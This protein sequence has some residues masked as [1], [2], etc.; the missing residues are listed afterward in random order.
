MSFLQ[1]VAAVKGTVIEIADGPDKGQ[2]ISTEEGWLPYNRWITLEEFYKNPQEGL[3]QWKA[4]DGHR[5]LCIHTK[6]RPLLFIADEW[7]DR[8][9]DVPLL[10]QIHL[11]E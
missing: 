3:Y 2:W 6:G 9:F 11:P 4:Q 5:E 10:M 8:R 7:R 1:K